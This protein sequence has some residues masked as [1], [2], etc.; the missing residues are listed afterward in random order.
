MKPNILMYTLI[1]LFN[2]G[3]IHTHDLKPKLDSYLTAL[4]EQDKFSGSVL[5]AKE[6]E[7][8]LSKGYGRANYE[9]DVANRPE[10]KFRLASITKQ[11]TAMAIMQL[12]EKALLNVNDTLSK[13]ISEFPRSDEITIHHLLTHSSGIPCYDTFPDLK[14]RRI[15][16]HSLKQQVEWIRDRPLDFQPG[17]EYRYSNSGYIVLSYIIEQVSGKPYDIVIKENIFEPLDMNDSG[18]DKASLILKNRAAGY[19]WTGDRLSN[20]NY[21]DMSFPVGSGALYS[22]VEDLYRWDQALY[23]ETLLYKSMLNEIFTSYIP[24]KNTEDSLSYGYGV[25]IREFRNRKFVEHSGAIEGFSTN[26]LRDIDAKICIIVLSN[27]EGT[28]THQISNNLAAIILGSHI[29]CR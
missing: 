6:G 21:V 29:G 4:V 22:S 7:I 28:N 18:Y 14:Q 26:I 2:S 20:A 11:F 19:K 27:F 17:Q 15:E 24:I 1:A 10:T 23:S 8:L 25:R 9:H 16:P 3:C 13:Y 5:V 12:Q